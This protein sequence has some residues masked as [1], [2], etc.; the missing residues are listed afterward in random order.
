MPGKVIGKHMNLGY[1]GKISRDADVIVENRMVKLETADI[2]FGKGVILNTNNTYELFGATGTAAAFAG[3]AIAGVKQATDYYSNE[4]VYKAGQGCD[5][6]VRGSATIVCAVGTPAAGGKVY[7]RVT[8][9]TG[10]YVGDWEATSDGAKTIE[11]TNARWTT[12]YLDVNKVAE[13]TLV[14]RNN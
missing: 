13:V 1:A 9:D 6:L 11:I 4:V 8:A 14:E 12:G 5:V 7:I 10:K 3:I 2:A